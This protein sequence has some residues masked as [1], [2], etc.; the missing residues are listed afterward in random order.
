VA[1][2]ALIG[3]KREKRDLKTS[4]QQS[5]IIDNAVE[6]MGDEHSVQILKFI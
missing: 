2:G 5:P 4:G 6:K 3:V 1:G